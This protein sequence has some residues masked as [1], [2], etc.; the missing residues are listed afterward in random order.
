MADVFNADTGQYR[1]SVNTTKYIQPLADGIP[2]GTWI[3]N[4][5]GRKALLAA[6]VPVSLWKAN[7]AKDDV[8]EK[9]ADEKLPPAKKVAYSQI[10]ARTRQLIAAGFEFPAA[11]GNIYS[12]SNESQMNL[13]NLMLTKDDLSIYDIKI[14]TRDDKTA[15]V[16]TDK[17]EL[18]DFYDAAQAAKR[19]H[20]DSGTAL[21]DQIRSAASVTALSAITDNR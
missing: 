7:E 14:N 16:I 18:K 6:K 4:P 11:S 8:I 12:L 3:I 2:E 1:S 17:I 9:S 15:I 20:L 19:G 13:T 10:D 21:K 5:P